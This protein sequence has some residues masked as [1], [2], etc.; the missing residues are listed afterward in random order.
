MQ[1]VVTI[2]TVISQSTGVYHLTAKK[3]AEYIDAG[4]DDA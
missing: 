2:V 1:H 4:T 3:C